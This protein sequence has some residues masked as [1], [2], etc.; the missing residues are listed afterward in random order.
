M[1]IA[2][3]SQ[4]G[5]RSR[6]SGSLSRCWR[7]WKRGEPDRAWGSLRLMSQKAYWH[8][9]IERPIH[10]ALWGAGS[11]DCTADG[12]QSLPA[13][14]LCLVL[15][16]VSTASLRCNLCVKLSR[17]QLTTSWHILA[18]STSSRSSFKSEEKPSMCFT[19]RSAFSCI[20]PRMQISDCTFAI[21]C[22]WLKNVAANKRCSDWDAKTIEANGVPYYT[23]VG[24][25]PWEVT[26]TQTTQ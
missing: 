1:L 2:Y 25:T 18:L 3:R 10:D 22:K 9:V 13:D 7:D 23:L 19:H 21:L 17:S 5:E 6:H 20:F 8:T 12:Q 14:K 16:N 15:G 11:C 24:L 4:R 26:S